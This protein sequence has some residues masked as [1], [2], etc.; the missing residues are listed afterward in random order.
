MLRSHLLHRTALAAAVVLVL[1]LAFT[2]PPAGAAAATTDDGHQ[3]VR[4]QQKIDC[5]DGEDCAAK[6]AHQVV[7]VGEDGN[8]QHLDGGD[9]Q[10]VVE[11]TADAEAGAHRVVFIGEDGEVQHLDGED[12]HWVGEDGNVEIE[13]GD[14]LAKV[15]EFRHGGGIDGTYLG[16]GLTELTDELRTHFGAPEGSGVLVSEV[17]DDSPAWRAGLQVGDVVTRID[18]E[19][20]TSGSALVQAVRS[21][22]PGETVGVEVVRDGRLETFNATVEKHEGQRIQIRRFGA[23][24]DGLHPDLCGDDGECRVE[25]T[26]NG[27]DC[28]CTVNGTDADCEALHLQEQ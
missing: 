6:A 3:V 22:Q 7:F 24:H 23:H 11:A 25:V 27:G 12:L 8:V 28:N 2:A 21:H 15:F 10:W 9:V 5:K 20:V 18:G 1:A 14:G 13:F 4:V 26:C 16:I 17:M 19:P